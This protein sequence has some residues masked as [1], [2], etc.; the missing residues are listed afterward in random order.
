MTTNDLLNKEGKQHYSVAGNKM[1]CDDQKNKQV[2]VLGNFTHFYGNV[3][4]V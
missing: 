2:I 1:E 4:R 3:F